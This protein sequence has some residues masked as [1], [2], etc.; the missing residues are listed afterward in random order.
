M[1]DLQEPILLVGNDGDDDPW[2]LSRTSGAGDRGTTR[3]RRPACPPSGLARDV[4]LAQHVRV[5]VV[6]EAANELA[7]QQKR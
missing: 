1:F 5:D 6:D 3:S 2:Q 7:V 4:D